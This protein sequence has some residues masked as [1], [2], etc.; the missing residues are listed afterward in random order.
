[1]A[2]DWGGGSDSDVGDSD[3]NFPVMISIDINI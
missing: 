2:K 1:M 3:D